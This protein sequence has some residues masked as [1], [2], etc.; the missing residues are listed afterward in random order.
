MR[1]YRAK[2]REHLNSLGRKYYSEHL[3]DQRLYKRNAVKRK[4]DA[5]KAGI[6][7]ERFQKQN[8]LCAI[9]NRP[10]TAKVNGKIKD[11]AIDHNHAT[12]QIRQLL[13]QKCNTVLGIVEEDANRLAKMIDYL[14]DWEGGG[15]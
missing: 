15:S 6:Y 5:L 3:N 9:C 12:G 1:N 13:C 11:L 7:Q 8:G 4:R 10:E 2:H 14:L